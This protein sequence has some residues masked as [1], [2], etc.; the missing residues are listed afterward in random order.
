[1]GKYDSDEFKALQKLWYDKLQSE[2]DKNGTTFEDIEQVYVTKKKLDGTTYT[3][4]DSNRPLK[5]WHNFRFKPARGSSIS[6]NHV[7]QMAATTSYYDQAQSLLHTF[8]FKNETHRRIWELHCS[9]T[10]RRKI[11]DAIKQ[12]DPTYKGARISEI[13]IDIAQQFKGESHGT[14]NRS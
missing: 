10:S 5:S 14:S 1:M 3:K 12:M 11:A 8:K 9:G 13:I 7:E 4:L 2:P 6:V